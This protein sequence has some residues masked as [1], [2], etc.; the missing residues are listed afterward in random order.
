MKPLSRGEAFL[1]YSGLIGT[2]IGQG[3]GFSLLL[4]LSPVF[5]IYA[6]AKG[7]LGR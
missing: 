1:E 5:L 7:V 2:A 6:I 3:V 4:V